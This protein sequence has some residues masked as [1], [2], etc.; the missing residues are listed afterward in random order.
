MKI[1]NE[2][3]RDMQT[4]NVFFFHPRLAK[5]FIMSKLYT[6]MYI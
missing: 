6:P 2:R 5:V 3:D 1:W 4:E